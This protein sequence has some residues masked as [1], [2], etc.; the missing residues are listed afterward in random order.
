MLTPE[1]LVDKAQ[2]SEIFSVITYMPRSYLKVMYFILFYLLC[3]V[4][5]T[6]PAIIPPQVSQ[7]LLQSILLCKP[8]LSFWLKLIAVSSRECTFTFPFEISCA[9]S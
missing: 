4:H 1:N 3:D 7:S 9:D 2:K 8:I 6:A 5:V